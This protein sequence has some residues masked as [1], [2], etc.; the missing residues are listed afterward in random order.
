MTAL[1][2]WI[3]HDLR[4]RA[5]SLLA[6]ALA[7]M[8]GAAAIMIGAAGT[9][10]SRSVIERTD[11]A[12]NS[13]TVIA[14][15]N[16]PGFDWRPVAELPEVERLVNFAVFYFEVA[17]VGRMVGGFP[18]VGES[19]QDQMERPVVLE[20]RM[21]DQDAADEVTIDPAIHR[22]GVDVGDT[23]HLHL[24]D[25]VSGSNAAT[26]VQVRV[27]GITKDAFFT[28]EVQP[29]AAFYERYRNYI[30]GDEALIN[31]IAMLKDGDA[32]VPDFERHLAEIAG[33]P[34]DVFSQ[35][36]SAAAMDETIGLETTAL[37]ALTLAVAFAAILVFSQV[38]IRLAQRS[39]SDVE[40]MRLLGARRSQR[41]VA[42]GAAPAAACTLGISL[43]PVTA[44]FGSDVFPIGLGRQLEP[45]P[46]R[47]FDISVLSST[48]VLS[49]LVTVGIIALACWRGAAGIVQ[50]PKE[51]QPS[52]LT[53]LL[54][55]SVP[56]VPA[57]L[58]I[59]A[60]L[61]P[62]RSAFASGPAIV[63]VGVAIVAA[64]TT[65]GAGL[66]RTVEDPS[67]VGQLFDGSI[68]FTGGEQ[69]SPR[70]VAN[71]FDAAST[72]YLRDATVESEHLPIPVLSAEHLSGETTPVMVRD[73]RLPASRDEVAL[74]PDLLDEFDT[75]IGEHLTIGNYPML[76]V[77]E[78]F[79]PETSHSGYADAAIVTPAA[80][81]RFV[82][83][84]AHVKFEML[85]VRYAAGQDAAQ[86]NEEL[87]RKGR[88][89]IGYEAAGLS[90]V[91]SNLVATQAMPRWFAIFGAFMVTLSLLFALAASVRRRG[92][93]FGSLHALG[94]TGGQLGRSVL[95]QALAC[96]AAGVLVGLP[97]GYGIGRTVW[98]RTADNL[99]VVY[100][101]PFD[102]SRLADIA[103]GA[104]AV[105]LLGSLFP[106]V[107]ARRA[108]RFDRL[109]A[110]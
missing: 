31:A 81:D 82:T 44:W 6:L 22:E 21:A 88:V 45:S 61:T 26:D 24:V 86:I 41:A 25:W 65:F 15:P 48:A 57:E 92:G 89:G 50:R 83:D 93:A 72:Y 20:G 105:V 87:V 99:P 7:V 102:G 29:T 38:V 30:G 108:A 1:G 56:T 37:G 78:V 12:V 104:A 79:T 103:L 10:R 94:M 51:R 8:I 18:P 106:A 98:N 9:A 62:G 53:R 80:L 107:M 32:S 64:A 5:W 84:G 63:A 96:T 39:R 95:W 91:Q 77:G 109:P 90:E 71:D 42:L 2:P 55:G 40:V 23:L 14:V 110:E 4:A 73:G 47:M 100:H 76:V 27:V 35:A 49:W 36:E 75:A 46:G 34:I 66:N 74:G 97:L 3:A 69:F 11:R 59:R 54:A 70:S 19:Y 33:Q 101:T 67:T 85:E 43:A 28:W 52:R 68:M 60:A 13:A 17:E 58:G 16:L